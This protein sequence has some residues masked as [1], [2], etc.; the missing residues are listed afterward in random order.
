MAQA[1]DMLVI[2][3]PGLSVGDVQTLAAT[4]PHLRE[5]AG[6]FAAALV[7]IASGSLMARRATLATGLL[8]SLHLVAHDEASVLEVPAFWQRAAVQRP[9]RRAAYAGSCGPVGATAELH[10]R[11]EQG[12]PA[13]MPDTLRTP[14][15]QALPAPVRDSG[16]ADT[17]WAFAL[18]AMRAGV[19]LVWLECGV[20]LTCT[21][22]HR[23]AALAALDA[24]LGPLLHA[25]GD[26]VV[27]LLAAT[28]TCTATS[29]H[30]P[31]ALKGTRT[32]HDHRLLHVHCGPQ[33][34]PQI[35]QQLRQELAFS[36]VLSGAGRNELGLACP[37]AGDVIAELHPGWAFATGDDKLA[38][39]HAAPDSAPQHLPVFLARGLTLP[40]SIVGMCEVAW[41]LQ[42][43]L[44]GLEYRD[45]S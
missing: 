32:T 14:L 9:G 38:L 36:R 43:A 21:P 19:S 35:A 5:L 45:E 34:A 30:P 26:R 28:A 12:R 33:A 6:N 2:D 37:A 10:H 11:F 31:V 20:L 25:A 16:L 39:A 42:H 41:I 22:P 23:A 3:V 29:M 15:L 24:A 1:R 40:K 8:P 4:L 17:A 18:Q 13:W 44:A 7:P 27:I